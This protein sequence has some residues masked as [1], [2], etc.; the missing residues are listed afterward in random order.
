M[1]VKFLFFLRKC[2]AILPRR[3]ARP[4]ALRQKR[5]LYGGKADQKRPAAHPQG[6]LPFISG[7]TTSKN[8]SPIRQ[9]VYGAERYSA[10]TPKGPPRLSV[11]GTARSREPTRGQTDRFLT[12]LT[13]AR[14]SAA[15]ATQKKD[16]PLGSPFF[17]AQREGFEPSVP[18]RGTHDFQSCSLGRSDISACSMQSCRRSPQTSV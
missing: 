9:R 13:A 12:A 10:E 3:R 8:P 4:R 15:S 1:Q 14:G 16:C 18:L 6:A 5:L 17:V 2:A 7:F 11:A